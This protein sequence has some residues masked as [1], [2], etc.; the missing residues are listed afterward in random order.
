MT[1]PEWWGGGGV[2]GEGVKLTLKVPKALFCEEQTVMEVNIYQSIMSLNFPWSI[3]E[4]RADSPL[5]M[6]QKARNKYTS[7]QFSACL[8]GSIRPNCTVGV[9]HRCYIYKMNSECTRFLL[10]DEAVNSCHSC[11]SLVLYE[12]ADSLAF[13]KC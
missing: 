7:Q 8:K 12:A 4:N 11:S 5:L 9:D 2:R 6:V 3:D 10:P 1:M 13:G